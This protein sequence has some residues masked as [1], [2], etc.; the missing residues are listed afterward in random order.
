MP[1]LPVPNQQSAIAEIRKDSAGKL[2]A[3][4]TSPWNMWFQQFSQTAPKVVDVSSLSAGFTAN[5]NGTLILT[6]AGAITFTRGNVNIVLTGQ[7][8]IPIGIGDKV[9]W[10][11]GTAQFLGA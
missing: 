10:A 5:S 1:T 8:I 3:Y 9:T 6:G 4:L 2:L 7:R 11:G